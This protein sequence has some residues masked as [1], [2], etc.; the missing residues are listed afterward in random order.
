MD[1]YDVVFVMSVV[2]IKCCYKVST[3]IQFQQLSIRNDDMATPYRRRQPC[4]PSAL[5]DATSQGDI[6][7]RNFCGNISIPKKQEDKID[8]Y[9]GIFMLPFCVPVHETYSHIT[10]VYPRL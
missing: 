10:Y 2:L 3:E 8:T 4:L 1:N 5:N 7:A 6:N 9:K